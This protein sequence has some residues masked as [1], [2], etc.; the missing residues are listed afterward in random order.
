MIVMK[1]Y[2]GRHKWNNDILYKDFTMFSGCPCCGKIKHQHV[3]PVDMSN[4]ICRT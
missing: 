2:Y 1:N 3:M 4:L